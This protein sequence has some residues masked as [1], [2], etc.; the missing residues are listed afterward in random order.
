MLQ[1]LAKKNSSVLLLS[2]LL[3]AGCKPSNQS[4]PDQ[5][6]PDQSPTTPSKIL[7]TNALPTKVLEGFSLSKAGEKV[8]TEV[9]PA[10]STNPSLTVYGQ[11]H[12]IPGD[13]GANPDAAVAYSQ[14]GILHDLIR[15]NF[16]KV[17]VEGEYITSNSRDQFVQIGA[18]YVKSIFPAGVIPHELNQLQMRFFTE[19]WGMDAA[20]AYVALRHNVTLIGAETLKAN[21]TAIKEVTA[22]KDT[23]DTKGIYGEPTALFAAREK[24]AMT[25]ACHALHER[26]P[27]ALIY[28]AAHD[29]TKYTNM[30][31]PFGFGMSI[32]RS[33]YFTG[34]CSDPL[35]SRTKT[36]Q[37]EF[38]EN[39]AQISLQEFS[40]LKGDAQRI[41]FFKLDISTVDFPTAD[42]LYAALQKVLKSGFDAWTAG[43]IEECYQRRQGPFSIY[44]RDDRV[45]QRWTQ[46]HLDGSIAGC[47]LM[48]ERSTEFINHV[49]TTATKIPI[50]AFDE[51]TSE[52]LQLEALPKVQLKLL[53]KDAINQITKVKEEPVV[54][55]LMQLHIVK[56]ITG[57]PTYNSSS[58]ELVRD[59]L[60][61]VAIS[62]R[63]TSRIHEMYE[64]RS[65]VFAP[66]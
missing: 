6:T 1:A 48:L 11:F 28:G 50:E 20:H 24:I 64:Q 53:T 14:A 44:N 4:T 51:L 46:L 19:K 34:V 22:I 21:Q 58:P 37:M 30:L 59:Y 56:K 47:A 10:T 29:F 55:G 3:L 31:T 49:V 36:Q 26:E 16:K 38:V 25:N 8:V 23:T 9:L 41:S 43:L 2:G 27:V 33:P 39:S 42:Y 12:R 32:V 54:T 66:Q 18:R 17:L 45:H 15:C 61:S 65:G 13:T 52:A 5:S 7:A 35:I 62:P 40:Q 60:L 63:V 57:L